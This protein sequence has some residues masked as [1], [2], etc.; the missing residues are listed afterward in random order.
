MPTSFAASKRWA[1]PSRVSEMNRALGTPYWA[2]GQHYFHDQSERRD[3]GTL[4]IPAVL[5]A[6]SSLRF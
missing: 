5:I 1:V 2:H 3:N 6:R 4:V